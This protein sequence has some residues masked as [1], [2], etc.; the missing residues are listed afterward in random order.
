[1]EFRRS[2]GPRRGHG[3]EAALLTLM[4]LAGCQA[5]GRAVGD[6]ADPGEVAEVGDPAAS[7][8]TPR[9]HVL[10]LDPDRPR[11]R[12]LDSALLA[13]ALARAD[14]LPRLRCLLV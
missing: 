7:V 13:G 2:G 3:R 6:G 12:G 11:D 5:D 4:L 8:A 14:S 9:P 10:A 1:M